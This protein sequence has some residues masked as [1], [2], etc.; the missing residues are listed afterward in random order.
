MG[1]SANHEFFAHKREWSKRKDQILGYYLTPYLPKIATQRRPILVVDGFAGPGEFDDGE[2]GSPLIIALAIEHAKRKGKGLPTSARALL[3]ERDAELAERLTKRLVAFS[4]CHVRP[5]S[6]EECIPEILKAAEGSS[7]LLYLDPFT[8]EGLKWS[9]L[10]SVFALL[11]RGL[12]VEI[13]LNFNVHSF[14]RRGLAALEGTPP[15]DSDEVPVAEPEYGSP[16]TVDSLSEIIGGDWWVPVLQNAT[17]YQEKVAE[18]TRGFCEKLR[19]RFNEVCFH[20]V[21]EKWRH[22][23]P[24]Y[25]LVFGS[26]HPDA[27]LLMNDAMCKAREAFLDL[28]E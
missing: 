3:I 17:S 14:C 19:G 27:L 2:R 11:Q 21:R 22:K 4:H 6:F 26:R 1:H 16:S 25:V 28:V 15:T 12:S 5:Q 10:D 7:T 8:V 24:K 23:V 13:L 20:E 18:V 9:S